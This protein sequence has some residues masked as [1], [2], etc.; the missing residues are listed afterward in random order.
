MKPL[1]LKRRR[2][3]L[4]LIHATEPD[5]LKD[6]RLPHLRGKAGVDMPPILLQ[7]C[8]GTY[9]VRDG[10]HRRL[11]AI[12]DGE[13][14]IAAYIAPKG[15]KSP[16]GSPFPSFWKYGEARVRWRGKVYDYGD[17]WGG[18]WRKGRPTRRDLAPLNVE[19]SP[20]SMLAS[21]QS[22]RGANFLR[23]CQRTSCC[24][25]LGSME[26]ALVL[27]QPRDVYT[28]RILMELRGQLTL[29]V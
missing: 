8:N 16:T 19:S 13:T 21:T 6:L 5:Q 23:P 25:P 28:T 15:W 12:R 22:K 1:L 10:H 17:M 14:H 26:S 7:E 18:A 29:G 11:L 4:D 27:E 3:A 2:V 9:L 24:G 20:V